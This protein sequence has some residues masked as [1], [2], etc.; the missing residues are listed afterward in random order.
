[1]S[2]PPSDDEFPPSTVCVVDTSVLIEFKNIVRIEHQ[3]ALLSRMTSLVERGHLAFR[4]QVVKELAYGRFP[5]AP[6]AWI[7]NA[8]GNVRFPEPS[9]EYQVQVLSI[10]PQ[11]VDIEATADREVA[12]PY[13]AAMAMQI[14]AAHDGCRVVVA[15]NDC[16]DRLPVKLSLATACDRVGIEHWRAE[17]FVEWIRS[18]M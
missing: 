6:G 16:V 4:R 1:M 7:S 9:E 12:D 3:W 8:K 18:H 15:T 17:E 10:A 14:C 5:D 11:L 2:L 13:V